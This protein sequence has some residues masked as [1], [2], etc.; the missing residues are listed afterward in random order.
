MTAEIVRRSPRE[1]QGQSRSAG[2]RVRSSFGHGWNTDSCG[3][4]ISNS[5]RRVHSA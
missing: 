5:Q 1:A 4:Q 2:N 3:F